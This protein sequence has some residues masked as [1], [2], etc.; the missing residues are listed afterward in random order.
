MA[1][2]PI[3][4]VSTLFA[5]QYDGTN[6]ADI[7]A[8]DDFDFNNSSE[9]SG[10][11]SF[12][13]PPDATSYTINTGDWILYAQNQ[14]MLKNSNSE[15]LLQYTCNT[16]CN[17]VSVFS[18]GEQVRAIGVAPVPSLVLSGTANVD[19]TLH[20]AMPDTNYTAYAATFAGISLT[21]L[22]IN[23]VTVVDEDTVTVAVENTGLITLAGASLI[24][25]AVA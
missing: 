7:V 25:H 9:S 13:S 16:V 12:Q 3:N 24:V 4:V 21:D 8:L 22:Q 19:V 15:F 6:S 5:V 20:P 18:T 2:N 11:W 10:V 1:A 14:V 17:D 23:S